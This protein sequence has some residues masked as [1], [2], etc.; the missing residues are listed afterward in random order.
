MW[1]FFKAQLLLTASLLSHFEHL[2]GHCY[3]SWCHKHMSNG[4]T[5]IGPLEV[6]AC[7]LSWNVFIRLFLSRRLKG[8]IVNWTI[9]LFIFLSERYN[10]HAGCP[11][12]PYGVTRDRAT[13]H[14]VDVVLQLHR[15]WFGSHSLIVQ[16]ITKIYASGNKCW[17]VT[18]PSHFSP[19][20][21]CNIK[22]CTKGG[23]C[24]QASLKMSNRPQF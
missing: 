12:S 10:L 17:P 23:S 9:W 18:Y 1:R 3:W 5:V 21:P 19:S 15:A 14:H 11:Y 24:L 22:L 6:I 16:Q 8:D 20:H 2:C 13:F 4:A 7:W